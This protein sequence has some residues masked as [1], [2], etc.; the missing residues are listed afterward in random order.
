[1]QQSRLI[2][3]LRSRTGPEPV[4]LTLHVTMINAM[5]DYPLLQVALD[6]VNLKRAVQL[7]KESVAG[8][9][10]WIEA[11]TSLIKSEGLDSVRELR[12]NFPKHK[13]VADM[14]V[15]DTGRIE[16]EAASKAGADV[17]VVL[18]VSDDSTIREAVD[19]ARNY[20]CEIMVDLMNVDDLGKR[21]E[22]LEQMGVDY[23][24]VHVSIDQQMRGVDPIEELEKISKKINTPLAIAGGINSETA[25][26]AVK[27]GAS[28]VIVGGAIIKAADAKTATRKILKAMKEKKPSESKLYKKYRNPREVFE[29]VSTANISDAMHRSGN[30]KDIKPVSDYKLIGT[31]VTVK[32]YPGDWAKPVEAIDVAKQGEVIVI[33]CGGV[34]KAVW[35]EL[36]SNSCLQKKISGV[37]VDGTVRDVEEIREMKFPVY[38]RNVGSAAGE[39]KG[40]GEIN[41]PVVCGG[42]TVKP[43]DWIVGD[44]DGVV[45]VPEEKAVEVANRALDVF[46]K[47]NRIRG[48]IN[49]G[50]TLSKVVEIERWEKTK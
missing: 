5:T 35:G 15:M 16:V 11:G 23:I 9:A 26:E 27:K 19:A 38:A 10:G 12:K 24:C 28:I 37:V 40:M 50:S 31:A 43:G 48:E 13:I 41:I 22:A 7:A 45:V 8:G 29:M 32:T 1:M 30:M 39:P 44:S 14:K 20:G 21:A 3:L 46:E 17:V 25:A 33:D 36:A 34:G 49:K 2:I 6:F 42:L 4:F 18:G 47:E